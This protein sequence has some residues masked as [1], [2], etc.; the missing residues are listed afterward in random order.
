[1][2]RKNLPSFQLPKESVQWAIRHIHRF[3]DTDILPVP[4]EYEAVLKALDTVAGSLSAIDLNKHYFKVPRRVAVPK[5]SGGFRVA[6][7]LSPDDAILFTALAHFIAPQIEQARISADELKSCSFR[8]DIKGN[9]QLFKPGFGYDDFNRATET[10]L[11]NTAIRFVLAVDLAD[12]YNQISHHRIANNLEASGIATELFTTVENVVNSLASNHHS[13]GL[14]IG[15][16]ASIVFAEAAALDLDEF[17]KGK[18]VAFCRYVDDFRFFFRSEGEALSFLAEFTEV[19][20]MNHRLATNTTKTKLWGKDVF[21]GEVVDQEAWEEEKKQAHLMNLIR[22]RS[23]SCEPVTVE[24]LTA[25]DVNKATRKAI[26]ELFERAEKSEPLLVGLAKFVFQRGKALKSTMFAD[27]LIKNLDHF[28]PV[29][30]DVVDYVSAVDGTNKKGLLKAVYDWLRRD[31]IAA[32]CQYMKEWAGHVSARCAPALFAKWDEFDSVAADF[33][34]DVFNRHAPLV[35]AR[36]MQRSFIRALK[37]KIDSQEDCAKRAIIL[38]SSVLADDEK[39]HWLSRFGN[40]ND[41]VFDAC[42]NYARTHRNLI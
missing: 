30:G 15:P 12:F 19:L 29:T 1:M 41:A 13:R 26:D 32:G 34:T 33:P 40:K 36:L 16:A 28:A 18:G 6:S 21:G 23:D 14:P 2:S 9:G 3:G 27:R 20:F 5:A 11:K 8:L 37:E 42:V 39:Q 22:S 10:H 35:A 4:A 7:Q 38:A 17:L 25:T 31:S 24:D